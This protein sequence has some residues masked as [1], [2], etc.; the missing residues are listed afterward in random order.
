MATLTVRQPSS[1]ATRAVRAASWARR[2]ED[3]ASTLPRRATPV[4]SDLYSLQPPV[5]A[6]PI[7]VGPGTAL[8]PSTP[9]AVAPQATAEPAAEA[10]F[11]AVAAGW[12]ESTWELQ[13]GLDIAEGLPQDMPLEAWLQVYLQA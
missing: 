2:G 9:A 8:L 11:D 4:W 1:P 10:V 12:F 5:T 6:T 7:C 3:A 13:Q